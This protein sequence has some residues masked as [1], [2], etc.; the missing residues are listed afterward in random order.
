MQTGDRLSYHPERA[1]QEIAHLREVLPKAQAAV[2]TIDAGFAKGVDDYLKSEFANNWR[3]AGVDM[4]AQKQRRI[5]AMA[6]AQRLLDD[7]TR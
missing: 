6:R 5:D 7:A 4:N 3:A 2:A 1:E